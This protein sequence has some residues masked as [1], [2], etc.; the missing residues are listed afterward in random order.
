[1]KGYEQLNDDGAVIGYRPNLYYDK[2]VKTNTETEEPKQE[3]TLIQTLANEVHTKAL[4]SFANNLPSTALGALDY[5]SETIRTLIDNV[6]T[7]FGT[8]NWEK[9]NNIESMLSAIESGNTA[10]IKQFAD[11]HRH[12]IEGDIVPEIIEE[13][14]EAKIRL[15]A[16]SETMRRI[17]YGDVRISTEDAQRIDT[18]HL[19]KLQS[20]ENGVSGSIAHINYASIANDGCL[21]YSV[22]SYAY[23]IGANASM[24]AEVAGMSTVAEFK[25]AT[26]RELLVKLFNEANEEIDYNRASY[27]K[28]H[29]VDILNKTLYNYYDKRKSMLELYDLIEGARSDTLIRKIN[30]YQQKT[31]EAVQNANRAFIG[32]YSHLSEVLTY[33]KEKKDL[34]TIYAGLSSIF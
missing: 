31:E 26:K 32:C 22:K 24:L 11:Y 16:V 21:N 27:S 29:T 34:L 17:Y 4:S 13:L 12:N 28:Y 30:E 25:D 6:S 7:A 23:N 18:E 2:D 3:Q 9:F 20:I 33:E 15:D 5:T 1:M 14:Y 10:Y 8:G 19:L